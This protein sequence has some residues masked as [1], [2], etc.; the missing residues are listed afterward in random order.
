MSIG[1]LTSSDVSISI[2]YVANWRKVVYCRIVVHWWMRNV[3]SR[4]LLYWW[5][6]LNMYSI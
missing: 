3:H 6:L 1:L 4:V 2:S 5:I